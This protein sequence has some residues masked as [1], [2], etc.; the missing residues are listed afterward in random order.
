ME[1]EVDKQRL[2]RDSLELELQGLRH[3][4]LMVE[5]LTE[6]M[7]SENSSTSLLEDQLSR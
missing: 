2:I 4:L 5:D 7:A 6:S 3:R 1:V